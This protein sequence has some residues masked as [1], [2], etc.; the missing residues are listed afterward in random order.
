[1]AETLLFSVVLPV[2]MFHPEPILLFIT[3]SDEYTDDIKRLV[4]V[5]GRD[6][7]HNISNPHTCENGISPTDCVESGAYIQVNVKYNH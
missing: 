4:S 5:K 6:R 7:Y 2:R 3:C 1:M